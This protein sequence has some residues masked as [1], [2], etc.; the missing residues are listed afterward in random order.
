MTN[1]VNSAICHLITQQWSRWTVQKL[2]C[3][4][5]SDHD[6]FVK[7]VPCRQYIPGSYHDDYAKAVCNVYIPNSWS[8][9]SG[10]CGAVWESLL[11]AEEK[12]ELADVAD[13]ETWT[14]NKTLFPALSHYFRNITVK[15]QT[16]KN[17]VC[18]K[19][20]TILNFISF[21]FFPLG[22][23]ELDENCN[24]CER[25]LKTQ[26]PNA[27]HDL[28]HNSFRIIWPHMSWP[29]PYGHFKLAPRNNVYLQPKKQ[30]HLWGFGRREIS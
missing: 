30:V 20:T 22:D 2:L 23:N 3:R 25:Y 9:V 18:K 27:T 26:Q 11:S 1:S 12:L 5:C 13:N 4:P 17:D 7:A 21:F 6:D 10:S 24:K 8:M 29:R 16:N 14:E 28:F 15:N 19:L